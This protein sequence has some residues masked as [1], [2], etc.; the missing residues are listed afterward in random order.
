M[1][2]SCTTALWEALV[3]DVPNGLTLGRTQ[4]DSVEGTV[5]EQSGPT[6][7]DERKM[8]G[9]VLEQITRKIYLQLHCFKTKKYIYLRKSLFWV[10]IIQQHLAHS[11][12]HREAFYTFT[13]AWLQEHSRQAGVN[14]LNYASEGCAAKSNA[15]ANESA[16]SRHVK[17]DLVP[18]S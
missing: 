8:S 1:T 13:K 7:W 6:R 16:K 11:F 5:R 10:G 12:R 4:K 17:K 9:D 14:T 3:S 15:S 18:S 2:F